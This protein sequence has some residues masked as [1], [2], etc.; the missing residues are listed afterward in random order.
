MKVFISYTNV[1][2]IMGFISVSSVKG[3]RY[4]YYCV[5]NPKR[6]KMKRMCLGRVGDKGADE[7]VRML[8]AIMTMDEDYAARK[9]RERELDE[10]YGLSW[11]EKVEELWLMSERTREAKSVKT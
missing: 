10:A 2:I 6:R 1:S 11:E 9:R 3:K 5:Y 7:R 4:Y 8:R